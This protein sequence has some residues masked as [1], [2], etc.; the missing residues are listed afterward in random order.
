MDV[1]VLFDNY[2][3][4]CRAL[5]SILDNN[6]PRG[7]RV[8]AWQESQLTEYSQEARPNEL[9]ILH[10]GELLSGLDAWSFLIEH[11]PQMKTYQRMASRIGIAPP[12]QAQFLRLLGHSLRRLCPSCRG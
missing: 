1:V 7:W 9:Q 4:I 2:C 3:A 6:P 12:R 8:L 11:A 5:A 10:K